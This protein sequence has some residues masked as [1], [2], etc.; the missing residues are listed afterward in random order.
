MRFE[1][2]FILTLQ[3]IHSVSTL[4]VPNSDSPDAF[5][6]LRRSKGDVTAR[7]IDQG[8]F[9]E[10]QHDISPTTVTSIDDTEVVKLL[11]LGERSED[12]E[13]VAVDDIPSTITKRANLGNFQV[14]ADGGTK[15]KVVLANGVT[16]VLHAFYNLGTQLFT[17][18]WTQFGDSTLTSASFGI[19]DDTN[20]HSSR[21]QAYPVNT[22]YTWSSAKLYDFL[23]LEG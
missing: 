22:R 1:Y 12:V 6:D 17:F 7:S 16:I 18:Y 8:E 3:A 11:N 5:P 14:M 4:A 15:Y 13:L 10:L 23:S 20:G 9:L 2:L 21:I 19:L